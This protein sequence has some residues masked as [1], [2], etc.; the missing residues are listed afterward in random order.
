MGNRLLQTSLKGDRKLSMI[1]FPFGKILKTG[2]R[3]YFVES[4]GKLSRTQVE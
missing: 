4:A 2:D 1:T 3:T